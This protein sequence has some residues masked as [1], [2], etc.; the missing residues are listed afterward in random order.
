M[1]RLRNLLNPG[2]ARWERVVVLAF[3]VFVGMLLTQGVLEERSR[4]ALSFVAAVWAAIGWIASNYL[5]D[6]RP[7]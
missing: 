5:V 6:R 2:R 4:L 3:V 7:W 1:A